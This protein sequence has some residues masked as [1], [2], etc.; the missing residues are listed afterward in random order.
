MSLITYLSIL[1]VR[2][3]AGLQE[4]AATEPVRLRAALTTIVLLGAVYVPSLGN[5]GV[6]EKIGAVGVVAFP[7]LVGESTRKRVTPSQK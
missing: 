6:A 3:V 7:I 1:R 2:L 5:V 4:F